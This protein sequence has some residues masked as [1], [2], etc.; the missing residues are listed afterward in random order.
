MTFKY[1]DFC[2]QKLEDDQPPYSIE[3][4]LPEIHDAQGFVVPNYFDACPK[5]IRAIHRVVVGNLKAKDGK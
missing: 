2:G 4:I 3:F 1:C 5:C